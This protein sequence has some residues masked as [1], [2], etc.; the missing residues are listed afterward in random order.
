MSDYLTIQLTRKQAER[1]DEALA[2]LMQNAV[3]FKRH[4]W[5]KE[6]LWRLRAALIHSIE[7]TQ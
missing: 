2:N 1:A 3:D 4:V 5:E 7:A 6:A